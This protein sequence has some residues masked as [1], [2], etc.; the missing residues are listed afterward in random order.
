MRTYL[1]DVCL[2]YN[3][4]SS[5]NGGN[6]EWQEEDAALHAFNMVT[7]AFK[8]IFFEL[9]AVGLRNSLMCR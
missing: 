7:N 6:K 4:D 8:A 2:V 3:G 5:L 1:H 9:L